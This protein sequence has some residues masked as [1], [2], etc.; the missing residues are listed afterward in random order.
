MTMNKETI[1]AISTPAGVG[2]IAVLRISG[3]GSI[4]IAEHLMGRTL[5]DRTALFGRVFVDGEELDE[6]VAT[7]FKGPRSYTGEDVVEISCHGSIYVQQQLLSAVLSTGARLA[8]PGEF[9]LRSFLNGRMDLSQSEAVADLIDSV[10]SSQHRLAVNQ[11]R[12]GFSQKL[13]ELR[14]QMVDLTSLLELELDFSDEEVEFADRSAL[15]SLLADIR[16]EASRLVDSFKVGNAIKN[17]VPVAI[18]GRPNV[19]K[20]TLLN[21]LLNDDRAIVSDVPGTTRDTIEDVVNIGGIVFRFVDTAGI[22]QS[23]DRIESAGIERSFE[24]ARKAQV[25]ILL[26][27]NDE[28]DDELMLKAHVCMDGKMLLKVRNKCDLGHVEDSG[29]CISAKHGDGLEVLKNRLL[30]SVSYEPDST[31]LTNVRHYEAMCHILESLDNVDNG[32]DTGIPADLVVID[33]R[34]ALYYLGTITGEVTSDE[35]LGN[36]FSRFCIGK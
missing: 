7:L 36:I 3:E 10:S 28:E 4:A 18:V 21:A 15:R 26:S 12:G 9:T 31:L 5:R 20:S 14:R 32:L 30:E 13:K 8:E 29:I 11:L 23:D 34:E 6:V 25:V 35:V 16:R 17:G 27:D 19:G 1:A 24:A 33:I 22:R 2:G